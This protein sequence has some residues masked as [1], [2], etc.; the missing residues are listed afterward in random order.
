MNKKLDEYSKLY[1]ENI[2]ETSNRSAFNRITI[3]GFFITINIAILFA[4]FSKTEIFQNYIR[5]FK[6]E[7]L[8][9]L[10][11]FIINMCF[12]LIHFREHKLAVAHLEVM[13]DLLKDYIINDYIERVKEKDKYNRSIT[14]FISRF[15]IHLFLIFPIVLYY[16]QNIFDINY[17]WIIYIVLFIIF[18]FGVHYWV[19]S[20]FIYLWR[21]IF[22][23]L[24]KRIIKLFK[25]L[26]KRNNTE[27]KKEN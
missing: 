2:L 14:E 19:I 9:I 4:I 1:L 17:R 21:F 15:L 23:W 7:Y 6:L 5:C 13:D 10:M 11:Q 18:V 20:R 27:N 8:L 16:E 25:F 22:K 24:V 12:S 26:F 3:L